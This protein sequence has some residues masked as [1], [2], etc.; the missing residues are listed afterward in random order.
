MPL[1]HSSSPAAL[2]KNMGVLMGDIGKSPHVQ[3]R[4]QA[5]A[6]GLSTQRRAKAAGHA[7]GGVANL[8]GFDDGGA[9]QQV[10]A[11][12]QAGSSQTQIGSGTSAIGAT[13]PTSPSSTVATAAT[14]PLNASPTTPTGVAPATTATTGTATP[15]A[16]AAGLSPAVTTAAAGVAPITT[17]TPTPGTTTTQTTA[18]ITPIAQKLMQGGGGLMGGEH[19]P[20]AKMPNP[21]PS[22]QVRSEA[23][24]MMH[25]PVIGA[26]PGRADTRYTKVPAGS[27]VLPS[28]TLSSLGHGNSVAGL[29]MAH[30]M[31]GSGAHGFG[32]PQPPRPGRM[33]ADGGY[34]SEGGGR[35][36][37]YGEPVDVALSDSEYVVPPHEIVRRWGSLKN[38]HA[39]LDA[40][41]LANRKKEIETLRKLP[42]PA[43][44]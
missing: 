23:R 28:A 35:G 44:K 11:A 3:S 5:I 22:W 9:V 6:I 29:A 13:N 41:V 24:G 15:T 20:M 8:P 10:L 31:F 33:F 43:K 16:S 17:T 1:I 30:R 21:S 4:A 40:F 12:L 32:A 39:V 26:A 36:E 42:P 25:G 34:L 7:D 14:N 2:K 19:F 18:P 38:G 27:Y 37:R